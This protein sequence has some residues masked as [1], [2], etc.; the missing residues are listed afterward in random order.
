MGYDSIAGRRGIGWMKI[1][2]DEGRGRFYG[3]DCSEEDAWRMVAAGE[4]TA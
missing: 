2:Y 1:V 4:I 3:I